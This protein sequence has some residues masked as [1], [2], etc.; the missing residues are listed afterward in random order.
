MPEDRVIIAAGAGR[1]LPAEEFT[2]AVIG[3]MKSSHPSLVRDV[4]EWPR[5]L[6][7]LRKARGCSTKDLIDQLR[8]KVQVHEV[9]IITFGEVPESMLGCWVTPELAKRHSSETI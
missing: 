4:R 5:G 8:L 1:W 7:Q 2:E 6:K 3:A 9:D